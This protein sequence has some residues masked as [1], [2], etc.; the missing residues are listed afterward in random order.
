M[1]HPLPRTPLRWPGAQRTWLRVLGPNDGKILGEIELMHA[2]DVA[3]VAQSVLRG[4]ALLSTVTA[5]QRAQWLKALAQK[6]RSAKNDLAHL[7]AAEGGKP[8]K[9]AQVEVDRAALTFDLC[10]EEALRIHGD[11][12]PLAH[13]PAARGKTAITLREPIGPVLALSAFNHPLNL[14]A[15]QVGTALASGNAVVFKPSPATPFCAEWL[16]DSLR[17]VGVP[18]D[19]ALVCHADVP[20]IELLVQRAEFQFVSFIGSARVGWQLRRLL[21]PG[22]RLALEH[23]GVATAILFPDADLGLAATTLVR[24]AFYHSGQVCIS[25][26]KI[27]VHE[28]IW[29]AFSA[30]LVASTRQL[31]V[32]DARDEKTDLGPLIRHSEVE[33]LHTWIEEACLLGARVLL[34]GRTDHSAPYLGPT[35]LSH[36]PPEA[37]LMTEE[38]FGPIVCLVPFTDATEAYRAIEHSPFHFAAAVYTQDLARGFEAATKLSAMNVMVNDHTAWR[39]DEMPFGGHRQSG[40]GMGGVRWAIEEQTRLKQVVLPMHRS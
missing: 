20:V 2:D 8:L 40:L 14:L 28:S 17:E 19:V 10:A 30:S 21:A 6:V 5:L 7:I 37:T 1:W 35:I 32:G 4:Q 16:A 29:D 36:V 24:G 33:R 9:D 27:F 31:K 18:T 34:D 13:S 26:Q 25:T 38:A 39:V 3:L 22:T 23:G 11:Q 15:H 12:L